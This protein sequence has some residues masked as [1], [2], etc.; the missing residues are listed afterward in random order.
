MLSRGSRHLGGASKSKWEPR[1]NGG[2]YLKAYKPLTQADTVS[3]LSFWSKNKLA[4]SA[5]GETVKGIGS[6][7]GASPGPPA[8]LP[9]PWQPQRR[10]PL[11]GPPH[12]PA[13]G[14]GLGPEVLERIRLEVGR[15]VR[16]QR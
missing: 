6:E 1:A 3:A 13:S 16:G 7:P 9:T 8:S 4:L 15:G 2:F 5:K 11:L 14:S 10:N 12:S